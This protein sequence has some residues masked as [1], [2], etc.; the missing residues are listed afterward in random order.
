LETGVQVQGNLNDRSRVD[1]GW[2]VELAFPWEGMQTL[3]G[4]R[5]LPPDHGDVWRMDFS[6]FEALEYNGLKAERSPGW[7][8]NPHGVYDSH[9]PECF[10]RVHFSETSL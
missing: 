4:G 2:T 7:S 6:R 9:I 8:F 10:T 5:S 1:Q 3:A